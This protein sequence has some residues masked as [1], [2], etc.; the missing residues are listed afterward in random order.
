M[1]SDPFEEGRVHVDDDPAE[2]RPQI[3]V[4][5]PDQIGIGLD[6]G[7]H[8]VSKTAEGWPAGLGKDLE[9]FPEESVALFR[10]HPPVQRCR[11]LAGV[12]LDVLEKFKLIA[13]LQMPE[14]GLDQF[15][16][17]SSSCALRKLA[18]SPQSSWNRAKT[19]RKA[20]VSII[21]TKLSSVVSIALPP[22]FAV[23]DQRSTTVEA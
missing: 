3:E 11:P 5:Q 18:R 6:V 9:R 2:L 16:A 14:Q 15:F 17:A 22:D 1:G 7:K 8:D 21:A 13:P 10:Q 12:P 19:R 23:V 20:V 4:F